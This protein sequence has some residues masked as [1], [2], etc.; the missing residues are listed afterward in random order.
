MEDSSSSE[1]AV[2]TAFGGLAPFTF[3]LN[4]TGIFDTLGHIYTSLVPGYYNLKV[5]DSLG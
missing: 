4:S 1:P 3:D 5:V 2:D